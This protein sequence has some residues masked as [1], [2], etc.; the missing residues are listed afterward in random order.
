LKVRSRSSPAEAYLGEGARVVLTAARKKGEIESVAKDAGER[1][2]ALLAEVTCPED[3]ERA[4]SETPNSSAGWTCWS[5][6][7]GAG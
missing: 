2:L 4:V 3:C 6:T 5:T 1:V 7:P